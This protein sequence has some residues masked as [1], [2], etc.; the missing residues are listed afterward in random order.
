MSLDRTIRAVA[1]PPGNP[2]LTRLALSPGTEK[3]ALDKAAYPNVARDV[4]HQTV[5]MSGA[6]SAFMPMTL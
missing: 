3:D 5:A 1:D 4:R 2:K 6:S